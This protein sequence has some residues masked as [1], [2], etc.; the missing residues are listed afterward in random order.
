MRALVLAA[1]LAVG[2]GT[3]EAASYTA[4]YVFGDSL[5]DSGNLVLLTQANPA[6]FPGFQH[7]SPP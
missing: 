7:P 2:A 3:A 1:A 5:T 4:E 6:L